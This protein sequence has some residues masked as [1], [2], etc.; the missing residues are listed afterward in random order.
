[1]RIFN[2]LELIEQLA[3]NINHIIKVYNRSSFD[4]L[5]I[6]QFLLSKSLCH[7]TF[8]FAFNY[9]YILIQLFYLCQTLYLR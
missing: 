6:S 2:I 1:M 3:S 4:F 9:F 8:L 5:G 7:Q